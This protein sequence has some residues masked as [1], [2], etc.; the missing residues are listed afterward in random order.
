MKPSA[1]PAPAARSLRAAAL[2]AAFAACS[3][4]GAH[5]MTACQ[6]ELSS[7]LLQPL[8]KPVL[9]HMDMQTS[10]PTSNTLAQ[11]FANGMQNAG[12]Q[13]VP[14][15]QAGTINLRLTWNVLAQGGSGGGSGQGGGAWPSSSESF[16]AGGIQRANPDIPSYDVFAPATPVQSGL[17]IFRAQ[18]LDPSSGATLWIGSLQCTLQGA[19]N[20]TLAYQ[21]GQAIGGA[22]GKR[23]S[24]VPM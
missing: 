1:I 16:L 13:V 20:Q 9:I 23:Q 5:A 15:Q 19:D 22:F 18:A 8:P 3:A 17:L 14:G 10:T 4:P 12:A 21:L 6:G 7:T 2:A 11:A 24:R